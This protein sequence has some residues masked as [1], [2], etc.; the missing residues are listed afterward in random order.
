MI[1]ENIAKR[2]SAN[3]ISIMQLEKSC[4]IG[5]GTIGGWKDG[6]CYPS[7]KS[8]KKIADYFHISIDELTEGGEK[9]N[10]VKD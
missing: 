5:N 8:L 2:C 7:Y 9:D 1:Y 10:R 6:N 3:G 4:R